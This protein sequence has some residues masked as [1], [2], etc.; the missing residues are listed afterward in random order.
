MLVAAAIAL[1]AWLAIDDHSVF[2]PDEIHQSVEQ[3]HRA[4]FGYG[5]VSWEFR[6]GAR[7]WLFP[8][9]IAALWELADMLGVHS[10]IALITLA[11][12][13]MV[14]GSGVAIW[15]AAKL[16]ATR[17]PRAGIA[18]AVVLCTFPP[19]VAFGYR[20]MSETASAPLIVLGAWFWARR[21]SRSALYAGL[22]FAAACLLRYQN[23][24]FVLVFGVALLLQRRWRDLAGFLGV[25]VAV[26]AVGGVLDWVTWGK[27]FHSLLA[28]IDFNLLLG[29]A[30]TF[31]VEPFSFYAT[32]LW[33]S[34]GPLLP[35][36][37]ACFCV[38]A[39]FAPVLGGA[40]LAYVL[41][42]SVLPH[43][44]FRF[45]VPCLPLFAAVTGIGF[46]RII[47]RLPAPRIVGIASALAATVSFGFVLAHLDYQD[48]GQY[49]GTER[50]S[51]SVWNSEEEPTLLLA[52]AGQREDLCGLAVLRAR[53]AFTGGYTYLH[54]DVPLIYQSELCSAAPANYVIGPIHHDA[55]LLP[56]AYTLEL[57]RGDWGLY[58]REGGCRAPDD[59]DRMLE[60]ARDMGLKRDPARQ[61]GDGSLRLDL[62][63]DAG[64]FSQGWGNGEMIDCDMARWAAGKRA[65]I[66]FEFSPGGPQYV[67]NLKARAHE[68]ATPQRFAIAI[69]GERVHV[70][71]LSA[72]LS[73][74][75]IVVPENALR[76]GKNRMELAFAR[77]APAEGDDPRQLA[78]L[79]RL[80]EIVPR[81]D[82]FD[83]DIAQADARRHLVSGW[84]GSEQAGDT[85][86]A[87]SEGKSSEVEGII[88]WPRSPYVL[89][90]V[91]EA[92]PLVRSQN[93]RVFVNDQLVGT[94]SFQR[95]WTSERL[96]VPASA[97][98]KG[99]N[100]VRFEYEAT[101]R[102]AAVSRKLRDQRELAVR[103]GSIQ[104]APM[105]AARNVDLGTPEAR[106][107]LLEGWSGDERDGDRT[108]VWS[109]GPSASAILSFEGIRQP[110]LRLSAHGYDQALPINVGVTI[111]GATVTSFAAPD[112]WQELAIP[113]RGTDPLATGE[114]VTF[115]FDHTAKPSDT[116]PKS[117]DQRDLALRVDRIWVQGSEDEKADA[118]IRALSPPTNAG[119]AASALDLRQ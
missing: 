62:R 60:G 92:V 53:A 76:P 91:A 24:I 28:Y 41:A 105:P 63:R 17:S 78:A 25:G 67:L 107:F 35:V 81:Q 40:V 80:I 82:D 45:L 118:S 51:L 10:S 9:A 26:A 77:T 14:V 116:N 33:S 73:S 55:Q 64:A 43:K 23:G 97:L 119:V 104:L 115:H 90:A 16:A 117:S 108:V 42:H 61:A 18:A 57:Q 3:A 88:A 100:R 54:R 7:S 101:A 27:P 93:T 29:G 109:D 85:T 4:V 102:P 38:G 114:I 1:R 113:L 110:I 32:T 39:F 84:N 46:E 96:I 58:R 99:K 48:M 86:F 13:A 69:N 31:G 44:E 89:T 11:R 49:K 21:D 50:A 95:R 98:R 68:L 112:G 12:L 59:Q 37:L 94:M 74:Y 106:P 66:D 56:S 52:E 15:F 87:W 79:F 6:D 83:V 72:Q 65:A 30:S 22:V 111:N 47:R 103:F 75:S 5:L 36:I 19:A 8:G 71:P 2:W 70:G 34:V 20:T